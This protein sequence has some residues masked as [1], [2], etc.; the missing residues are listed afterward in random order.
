MLW[1]LLELLK[2]EPNCSESNFDLC[3]RLYEM[4]QFC[5][6]LSALVLKVTDMTK[7]SPIINF[8]REPFNQ[9]KLFGH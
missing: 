5:D 8:E 3:D 2:E 9:W 6:V 4:E 1:W 7:P